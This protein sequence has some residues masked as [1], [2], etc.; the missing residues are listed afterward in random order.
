MQRNKQA[1]VVFLGLAIISLFLIP[2]LD[3]AIFQFLTSQGSALAVLADLRLTS[4]AAVLSLYYLTHKICRGGI[5]K[6]DPGEKRRALRLAAIWICATAYFVLV[7]KVWV[8]N[9]I[10]WIDYVAFF[11]TGL[12]AEEFLFRGSL[13]ELAVENFGYKKIATFSVPVWVTSFLFGF[14]HLGYHHFQINT[15]SVT[16]VVYTI[17]MG[18]F[19]CNLRESTGYLWPVILLHILTNSFTAIRNLGLI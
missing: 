7:K 5:H 10:S 8:P 2:S 3:R 1:L 16:Q 19:F 4:L 15:S 14:Q 6:S 17:V 13:Y 18:L 11:V 9:L 12:L